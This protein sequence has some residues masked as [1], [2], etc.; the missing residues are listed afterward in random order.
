MFLWRKSKF[1]LTRFHCLNWP[2]YLSIHLHQKTLLFLFGYFLLGGW[3]GGDLYW[4]F[5]I[6]IIFFSLL[7]SLCF[8]PSVSV[9]HSDCTWQ[10]CLGARPRQERQFDICSSAVNLTAFALFHQTVNS[11]SVSLWDESCPSAAE[12]SG[13]AFRRS[14][15]A[16]QSL[17]V[18]SGLM[19]VRE[20]SKEM[21]PSDRQTRRSLKLCEKESPR[22]AVPEREVE[23]VF[24]NYN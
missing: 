9:S 8:P 5:V 24:E 4:F 13:P 12:T 3:R 20:K 15:P 14:G 21:S 11:A 7:V 23:N 10:N 17:W 18:D 19:C 6:C 22:T 16:K 2:I 1:G